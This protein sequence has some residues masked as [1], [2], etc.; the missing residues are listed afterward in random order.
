MNCVTCEKCRLWG[1]VQIL[2][3]GTAIKIL[4]T[5]EEELVASCSVKLEPVLNS[6]DCAPQQ[7][8]YAITKV[9]KLL[10]R[11]EIIALLNTLNQFAKS[12][13][14]V[15]NIHLADKEGQSKTSDAKTVIKKPDK[16]VV[17]DVPITDSVDDS[18]SVGTNSD[19]EPVDDYERI[20]EEQTDPVVV[21]RRNDH[22]PGY[23]RL[24][25]GIFVAFALTGLGLMLYASYPVFA[26]RNKQD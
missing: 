5:P 24:L 13:E 3:F 18:S 9:K 14:F 1:K 21:P 26:K 17:V 25:F 10:S 12:I 4:L 6:V 2:G 15:A 23:R 11:Q 8:G 19:E 7:Q 20:V 22:S 16:N